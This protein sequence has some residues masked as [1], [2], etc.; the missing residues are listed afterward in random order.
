MMGCEA[1]GLSP[2]QGEDDEGDLNSGLKK[3]SRRSFGRKKS[4]TLK[5]AIFEFLNQS[6]NGVEHLD[7]TNLQK[8]WS[9]IF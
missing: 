4:E 2:T 1:G 3:K 5:I 7:K 9:A 8:R 6:L